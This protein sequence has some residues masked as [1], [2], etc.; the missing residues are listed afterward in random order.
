M[1]GLLG[2]WRRDR[3][4][5]SA[6]EFAFIAPVLILCYFG[7]AELCGALLAQRKAGHAASEIGDLLAQKQTVSV[8]NGDFTSLFSVGGAVMYPLSAA[9]L[10]IRLTDIYVDASGADRVRWS[11]DNG[12]GLTAYAK[13]TDLTASVPAGMLSAGA[14]VVK[15]E[16]VFTYTSPVA[17]IIKAAIPF[18]SAFYL[19][20]RQVAE[21]TCA[22]C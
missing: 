20:P 2:R 10:K 21:I 6:V 18:N 16:T 4:G 17:I 12:A 9:N 7:V 5:V 11:E 3:R 8:A 19:A 1:M 15:A 22:D 14:T 13:N